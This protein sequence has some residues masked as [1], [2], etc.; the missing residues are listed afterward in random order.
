MYKICHI[1]KKKAEWL[2]RSGLV[3]CEHTGR[4]TRCYRIKKDDVILWLKDYYEAPGKYRPP[5]DWYSVWM[6]LTERKSLANLGKTYY[7]DKL[8]S[9]KKIFTSTEVWED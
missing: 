2:I 7:S 6:I 9:H 5:D 4:K 3:P 8:S 1:S